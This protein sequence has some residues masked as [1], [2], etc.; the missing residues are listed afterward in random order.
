MEK[1]SL[2][3]FEL[4]A[5]RIYYKDIIEFDYSGIFDRLKSILN[6]CSSYDGDNY[7][8]IIFRQYICSK[9]ASDTFH[10]I[11]HHRNIQKADDVTQVIIFKQSSDADINILAK[12]KCLRY[13]GI[14]GGRKDFLEWQINKL[15]LSE[16]FDILEEYKYYK[17]EKSTEEFIIPDIIIRNFD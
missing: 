10:S 12:V 8:E 4:C 6:K 5:K 7:I 14:S 16:N 11:K 9:T 13:G 2:P 1:F 17:K 15:L 3:E